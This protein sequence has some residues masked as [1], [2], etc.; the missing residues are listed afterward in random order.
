MPLE[1]GDCIKTVLMLIGAIQQKEMN[2]EFAQNYSK[3]LERSE[4]KR[5]ELARICMDYRRKKNID[6]QE[7][8]QKVDR[9]LE[10]YD[11]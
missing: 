9:I 2:M 4:G 7:F 6:R 10:K 3:I 11:D 8:F 5:R 1:F